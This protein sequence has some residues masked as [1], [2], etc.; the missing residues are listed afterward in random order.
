MNDLAKCQIF[1]S[2]NVTV[3][4]EKDSQTD[5][6]T[7]L[8]LQVFNS[9]GN[10]YLFIKQ[11]EPSMAGEIT[12]DLHRSLPNRKKLLV[13]KTTAYLSI[14]PQTFLNVE[15]KSKKSDTK[16]LIHNRPITK[17]TMPINFKKCNE[18][19]IDQSIVSMFIWLMEIIG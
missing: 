15:L 11:I 9:K 14:V 17:L 8:F 7:F 6:W 5:F 12:C 13:N 3:T 2:S 10:F 19:G 1:F 4:E 16:Q 18:N